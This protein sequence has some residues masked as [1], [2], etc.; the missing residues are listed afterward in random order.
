MAAT[1]CSIHC[2][3]TAAPEIPG[4]D[5]RQ[6]AAEWQTFWPVGTYWND[7]MKMQ[8]IAREISRTV[9]VPILGFY[10][11]DEDAL[12][13]MLYH[14]GKRVAG[15]TDFGDGSDAVRK[16]MRAF[17][18]LMGEETSRRLMEILQCLDMD[19]KVRLLE[20]YFGAALML[21]YEDAPA[22]TVPLHVWDDALYR[23]YNAELQQL[24]GKNAL[25]QA[26]MV[27]EVPGILRFRDAG[28]Q[29]IKVRVP[30]C[31]DF[32][33]GYGI[34]HKENT[35]E[36]PAMPVYF[37]GGSLELI[38]AE[39][40]KQRGISRF[41][42]VVQTQWT[43]QGNDV[44]FV[45]EVAV[46]GGKNIRVPAGWTMLGIWENCLLLQVNNGCIAVMDE[47]QQI[48]ALLR[49]KGLI[50]AQNGP[51]ILTTTER[52]MDGTIRIYRLMEKEKKSI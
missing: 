34:Y 49:L 7:P 8:Q 41:P 24:R 36:S 22:E 35:T 20:E 31:P 27:Q 14:G 33:A 15:Y 42:F 25:V 40:M 37:G 1:V 17:A 44:K 18:E 29:F 30:D 51:Y 5:F 3:T 12:E 52:G 16:N 23:Q 26:K 11:F 50:Q 19:R 13:L 28:F 48:I 2:Y 6:Y 21:C 47:A 10:L 4:K 38:T 46:Y 39:E 32:R 9:D 43:Q 45:P